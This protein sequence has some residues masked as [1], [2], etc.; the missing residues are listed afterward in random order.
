[1]KRV[2]RKSEVYSSYRGSELGEHGVLLGLRR[3]GDSYN[4]LGFVSLLFFLLGFA[5]NKIAEETGFGFAENMIGWCFQKGRGVEQKLAKAVAWYTKA[6]E[7]GDSN[8]MCNLGVCFENGE[9]VEQNSTKA[10]EWYTKAA[11]KGDS[12]AMFNLGHIFEMGEGVE[13]NLAKAVEWYTK[14]QDAGDEDAEAQIN[15]IRES[16]NNA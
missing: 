3:H 13:Q 7:K 10:V 9:G 11:E 2:R 1:M 8:A 6:A 15:D 14:A 4:I 16:Q 5:E 12:D